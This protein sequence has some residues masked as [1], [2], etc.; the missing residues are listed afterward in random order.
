VVDGADDDGEDEVG[1]EVGAGGVMLMSVKLICTGVTFTLGSE[2]KYM[3]PETE[4]ELFKNNIFL[5]VFELL[6]VL[7]IALAAPL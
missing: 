1:V 4:A 2:I 3:H 6:T 5:K 7:N